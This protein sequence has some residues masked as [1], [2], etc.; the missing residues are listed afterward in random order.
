MTVPRSVEAAILEKWDSEKLSVAVISKILN[1][2]RSVVHRVLGVAGILYVPRITRAREIDAHLSL[3]Q[4][5]LVKFPTIESSQL[6]AMC[7]EQGYVGSQSHFRYLIATMRTKCAGHKFGRAKDMRRWHWVEWLYLLERRQ[8]PRLDG[9]EEKVRQELFNILGEA[10]GFE[11]QKALVILA[12]QQLFSPATISEC[13]NI[14]SNTVKGYLSKYLS[15]GV[16]KLFGRPQKPQKC[17]DETIK[18]AVFSLLH[19]PPSLSNINRTS[20][21]QED[22]QRILACRGV[23]VSRDVIRKIVRKAGYKWRS[24]KT[25]L[26]SNDPEYREK[27]EKLRLTLSTIGPE[28]RF[29]SIDEFGPF[30]IK[31]TGGRVLSAPGEWPTVPQWQRSKGSL[32]VTAA[33]ELQKNQIVHFYSD[34]KNTEEMIRMAELL[35]D[36]YQDCKTLYLSWDAASWHISKTLSQF[37]VVHNEICGIAELPRLETLPLP[38]GAQ[39]LNVIES[40]FS[41]MARAII[42]N[43]NYASKS[44]AMSAVNR[45]FCERNQ[46]FQDHPQRAGNKVWGKERV[47][48][49]FDASNNCKDPAYR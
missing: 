45:Y 42:H 25:V 33:L 37:I 22:L 4:E 19:E 15:G 49:A 6:F 20:W 16:S 11:R 36:N 23:I 31:L 9:L 2:S 24:A 30:A 39:F 5:T 40:V 7:Q 14:S 13:M 21:K 27:L 17:N 48:S 12:Y 35:V 29:F 44:E 32:I 46:H 8:L 3:V 10:K 38:A 43:S 47:A 1:I 18:A 41:G 28:E 34:S 26:T